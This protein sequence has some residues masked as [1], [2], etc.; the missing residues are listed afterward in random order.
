[1]YW[2]R[3]QLDLNKIRRVDIQTQ[4]DE[5]F[6]TE[7]VPEEQIEIP[8]LSTLEAEGDE[9]ILLKKSDELETDVDA[10]CEFLSGLQ[11]DYTRRNVI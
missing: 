4:A 3:R 5:T 7:D 6:I 10:A 9:M 1:M 8:D 11:V 2:V